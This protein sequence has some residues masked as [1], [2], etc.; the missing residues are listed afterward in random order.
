MISIIIPAHNEA[1]NL[2][3][4][5]AELSH[6]A[7]SDGVEIIVALSSQTSDGSREVIKK[8]NANTVICQK[9]RAI[10]MNTAA[11][12]ARGEVL[13]FLHADVKPP[14]AFITDIKKAINAG[15]QAGFFSYQFDNDNFF[16]RINASFTAS[17]G[18]FTGGGDQCLFI[19][20]TIFNQMGG[21]NER[22]V[23]MEDFEFFRRMKNNGVIYTIIKNDLIVS[24]R[25]YKHNS[26][27]KVNLTNLLLV[28]LF[29]GGCSAERL[30]RI[31]D[32]LLKTA[33]N[34]AMEA[35]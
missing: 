33:P 7:T 13:V 28:L 3:L 26:Y 5:L 24:A 4:R 21:F 34:N 25:K 27:L 23:L 31:H 16:L 29:K 10:Q 9:G 17:D 20:K 19:K 6:A 1:C 30:K 11:K 22:Q 8:Y 32:R 2:D 12:A 15:F 35:L 18:I 14:K